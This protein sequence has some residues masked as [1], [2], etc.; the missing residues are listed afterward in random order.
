MRDDRQR[1]TDRQTNK[2]TEVLVAILGTPPRGEV[3]RT[4]AGCTSDVTV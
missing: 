2:E 1:Q 3:T 4:P